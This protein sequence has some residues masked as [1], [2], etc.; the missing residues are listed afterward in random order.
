MDGIV[1]SSGSSWRLLLLLLLLPFLLLLQRRLA[2]L[3]QLAAADVCPW[4]WC[5]K[6][7]F[8]TVKRFS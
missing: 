2:F 4:E 7:F 6:D 5:W 3:V 8:G 1:R